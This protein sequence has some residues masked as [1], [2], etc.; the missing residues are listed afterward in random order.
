[1]IQ[2]N[3][4]GALVEA[5]RP[6]EAGLRRNRRVHRSLDLADRPRRTPYAYVVDQ[7]LEPLGYGILASANHQIVEAGIDVTNRA[8]PRDRLR[9]LAVDIGA[10]FAGNTVVGHGDVVPFAGVNE[11]TGVIPGPG[12]PAVRDRP[13]DFASIGVN[14]ELVFTFLVQN[15]LRTGA[16][17][18]EVNPRL[19]G[20]CVRHL[21][22]RIVHHMDEIVA[23]ERQV[24]RIRTRHRRV[25]PVRQCDGERLIVRVAVIVRDPDRHGVVWHCFEIQERA[26]RDRYLATVG[27][28]SKRARDELRLDRIDQGVANVEHLVGVPLRDVIEPAARVVIGPDAVDCTQDQPVITR[29][30][31][32]VIRLTRHPVR[33]GPIDVAAARAATPELVVGDTAVEPA[34]VA[35]PG[36][37]IRTAEP[38]IRADRLGDLQRDV[39]LGGR[40]YRYQLTADAGERLG[41]RFDHCVRPVTRTDDGFIKLPG[42]GAV[43][44]IRIGGEQRG[45][46]VTTLRVHPGDRTDDGGVCG[47]LRNTQGQGR[48]IRRPAAA[49]TD[50]HEREIVAA[51]SLRND[52]CAAVRVERKIGERPVR[53]E[54]GFVVG[55]RLSVARGNFARGTNVV[56]HTHV[57]QGAGK[58]IDRVVAAEHGILF[59]TEHQLAARGDGLS[60]LITGK[61]FLELSV[62]IEIDRAVRRIP[63][64]ADGV[65]LAVEQLQ[66]RPRGGL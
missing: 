38:N 28:N 1:M 36:A 42:L 57:V 59:L 51:D 18:T 45:D 4:S 22:G 46:R 16:E 47:V 66:V 11:D 55:Q 50:I 14:P 65:L 64:H 31:T 26:V 56:E 13:N 21:Q 63:C 34:P 5:P 3:G 53:D 37:L 49:G 10:R 40:T 58:N 19:H 29:T 17:T 60:C 30:P 7:A 41:L 35:F 25:I 15:Q 62:D 44:E 6:G 43:G 33:V 12:V 27:I 9:E 20:Q 32:A 2:R 48:R 61:R 8:G 39:I 52:A 23:V 54:A 24:H